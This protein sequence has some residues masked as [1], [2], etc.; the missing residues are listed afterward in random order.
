MVTQEEDR[1]AKRRKLDATLPEEVLAAAEPQHQGAPHKGLDRPISPPLS[2]RKSPIVSSTIIVPTREFGDVS[3]SANVSTSSQ[4]NSQ[5]D[6]AD[7]RDGV[8]KKGT[9]YVPSPIQLTHIE[10]LAPHQNVDAVRLNDVLG[11]PLIKECWN[12]N[13][14]FDIDFVM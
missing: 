1:S 10:H 14:L 9:T 4:S 7:E 8:G 2:K 11:N 6:G 3:K 12:F 13:F 5:Q